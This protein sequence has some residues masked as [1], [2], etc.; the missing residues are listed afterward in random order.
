MEHKHSKATVTLDQAQNPAL[1][2]ADHA[3]GHGYHFLHHSPDALTFGCVVQRGIGL[4]ENVLSNQTQQVHRQC[5][6]LAHQV[7]G[8]ELA[9]GQALQIH[10]GLELRVKL[11]MGDMI[12]IQRDDLSG[13]ELLGQSRRPALQH[14]LGQQQNHP[15]FVN[16]A[17]GE[18]IDTTRR[19]GLGAHIDKLQ[20]FLPDA[21]AL[22]FAMDRPLRVGVGGLLGGNRFDWRA[23]WIPFDDESNFTLQKTSLCGNFMHQLPRAKARISADTHQQ[24][25]G[26]SLPNLLSKSEL[27]LDTMQK[28]QEL[29]TRCRK[30]HR[31]AEVTPPPPPQ[32]LDVTD[33]NQSFCIEGFYWR[34]RVGK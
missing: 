22:V 31:E 13:V 19:I 32:S 5:N 29:C 21:L 15:M 23:P 12:A 4:I 6:E 2:V 9:S 27:Q 3:S 1:S 17:L 20:T 34:I 14:L 26:K 18:E 33:R 16:G 7:V 8:I 25:R 30:L 28:N 10:V 11:L 24:G